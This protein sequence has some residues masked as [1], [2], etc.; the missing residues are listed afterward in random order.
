MDLDHID[1]AAMSMDDLLAL[2]AR[3]G[4][5]LTTRGL[6][7][8]IPK[9][10]GIYEWTVP[11]VGVYVG[12]ASNLEARRRNY[13]VNVARLIARKP[14]RP[15]NPDGFRAVHRAMGASLEA[16]IF[17]VL[18]LCAPEVL[19]ERENHHIALRRAEAAKGGLP[20]LNA[21]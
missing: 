20:L 19:F 15:K 5:E 14:Y 11:G 7:G 4:A 2:N 8:L 12:K 21:P 18:E 9:V 13:L 6:G 3:I 10:S 16:P 1:F 17:R